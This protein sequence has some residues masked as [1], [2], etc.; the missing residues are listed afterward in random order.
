[1]STR[2]EL[3]QLTLDEGRLAT[4]ATER[5]RARGTD[6]IAVEVM[7]KAGG[8]TKYWYRRTIKARAPERGDGGQTPPL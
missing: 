8:L 6:N 1:M 5:L 7:I 2:N 4:E 3:R